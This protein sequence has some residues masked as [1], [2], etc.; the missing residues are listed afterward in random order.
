VLVAREPREEVER[1][2]SFVHA[3]FVGER[4]PSK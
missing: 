4:F 2:A 3:S 1:M